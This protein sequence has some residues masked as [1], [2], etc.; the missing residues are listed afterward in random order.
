MPKSFIWVGLLVWMSLLMGLSLTSTNNFPKIDFTYTDKFYHFTFYFVLQL[1]W[2]LFWRIIKG[3]T[4]QNSA[5]YALTI[6]FTY[7]LLIE[8][9]Q[10]YFTLY[11]E[12]DW[13]DV[14]FNVLGAI[15]GTIVVLRFQT[16]FDQK[17][18]K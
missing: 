2:L 5:R 13:W 18:F 14:A 1:G 3:L 12:F 7:G 9:L 10:K 11:R 17:V 8:F 6:S 16:F 4:W 15:F